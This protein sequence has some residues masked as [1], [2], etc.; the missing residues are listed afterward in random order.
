MTKKKKSQVPF[1][2]N[3]LFF[4]VFLLF[5][6][7]VLKL[8][9][10]QI[11]YGEDAKREIARTEDVTVNT[12]VPRGKVFDRY[13]RKVIENVPLNAI[14]YTR[15]QGTSQQE[16]L[17][18]A[19]SLAKYIDKKTD[20]ITERDMKDYWIVTRPE[21]ADKKVTNA[22]RKRVNNDEIPEDKRLTDQDLYQMTLDRITE[23]DL[24]D[25]SPS[26]LEVIA[27]KRELDSGYALTPQ[28]VKN[29]EV[30]PEEYAVVSENLEALPGVDTTVDWERKY[31]FGNTLR[32]LL[33]NISSSEE[34]L[35]REQ[36][37]Y[38]MVR[39]YNRNDRVGKSYLEKQ[40]E[41]V[42]H[43]QK[44]KIENVTDKSGNLIDTNVISQGQ[45]GKDLVLTID[46]DLQ[47][48][49]EKIIEDQIKIAKTKAGTNLLDRA[50]VVMMNPKTGE[51][52][53]M[54]GKQY[55]QNEKGKYEFTD[56]SL[57]AMTTSYAM[58]SAVKGATV[59]TGYQTGA[60][61][62]GSVIYDAPMTI[63]GT[64]VKKSWKN[65]G[66][67]NDL[68]ALKLSSNVYMFNTAIRIGGGKYVPNEPISVN[69]K[70]FTTMRNYYSQ[71]GLGVKTGIDLPNESTGYRGTNTTPGLLLDLAIGQYDTYTPLQLA[72]YVS[73][74]ANGGYRVQPQIVKEIRQPVE[75]KDELGP[76]VR[77]FEPKVLN[78]IDMP[79]E[80]IKRVQTGFKMVMQSQGGT[81]YSIFAD[82]G[83]KPAGK[84]GTAEALYDGPRKIRPKPDTYNLTL[85]GYAPA[86]NPEI[87]FSVVVP[88]AHNV[89]AVGTTTS[90]S[91]NNIIGREALDAYFELKKKDRS[92]PA[93]EQSNSQIEQE[94]E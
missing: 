58:G 48:E 37:N 57:G 85:I 77:G 94:N 78:R 28:I 12:P 82:A 61:K 87:A 32:T 17:E 71:F 29:K 44:A 65:M 11:V 45:R 27:I 20:K 74:I 89:D 2:L 81:A 80:Q 52:L 41:S 49:V 59:L 90:Y 6:S 36:L 64:P 63:K 86:D 25:I 73:T 38:F 53:T 22:E 39:D 83:Y 68:T 47:R 60:I 10:V 21:L 18:I 31:E 9:L 7:L 91:I 93:D 84:T 56:F 19:R 79:L 46:M 67:I 70:A 55:Q 69:P 35:P 3:M 66:S 51:V 33:G 62:P 76:V 50:F 1:R 5:S 34:G 4:A 75:G 54:A 72:Q 23:E 14:T 30:T 15:V 88:W 16:R 92:Q 42:L 8:G 13:N 43:G 26:E 40:Y 24:S